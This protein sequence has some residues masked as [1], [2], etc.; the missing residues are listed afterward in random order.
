MIAVEIYTREMLKIF[1]QIT[2]TFKAADSDK[3]LKESELY[4][5]KLILQ[6]TRSKLSSGI[7]HMFELCKKYEESCD[8]L[9]SSTS[10]K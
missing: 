3:N 9:Q 6:E 1:R 2:E 10:R 7:F 8:T 5:I 4:A